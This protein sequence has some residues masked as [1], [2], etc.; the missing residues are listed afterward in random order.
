MDQLVLVAKSVTKLLKEMSKWIVIG[1]VLK[2]LL[3]SSP[4][5]V[6]NMLIERIGK[7]LNFEGA[8]RHQPKFWL[9]GRETR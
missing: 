8:A 2:S 7:L 1:L 4:T 3:T 5:V 9:N 6:D